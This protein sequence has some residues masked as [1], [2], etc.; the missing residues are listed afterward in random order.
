MLYTEAYVKL[1]IYRNL[2]SFTQYLVNSF[3]TKCFIKNLTTSV[4]FFIFHI[5]YFH[6][7]SSCYRSIIGVYMNSKKKSLIQSYLKLLK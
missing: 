7:T 1:Y 2:Q 6:L 5:I 3:V 4:F